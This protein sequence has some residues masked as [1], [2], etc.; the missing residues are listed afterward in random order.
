MATA[1]HLSCLGVFPSHAIMRVSAQAAMLV[2]TLGMDCAML[3]ENH[4]YLHCV[5]AW[6]SE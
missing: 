2:T 1:S 6:Y 4:S 5:G 3:D